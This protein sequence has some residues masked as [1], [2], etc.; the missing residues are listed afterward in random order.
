MAR[1]KG[2]VVSHA[3]KRSVVKQAKGFYD[4]NHRSYR[5][6]RE[7][8]NKAM[9]D[10]YRDR[11]KNKSN[12]RKLWILRINAAVRMYG[13]TYSQFIGGLSKA[14]IELDRKVLANLA[15]SNSEA[16]ALIVSKVKD[17]ISKK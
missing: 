11:R 14:N 3:R 9:Q 10:A 5:M 15:Y 17:T 13:I 7:R 12:F 16:F 8:T 6:A 4:R 1:V 2:G